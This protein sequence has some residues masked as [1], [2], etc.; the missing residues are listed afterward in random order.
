MRE[1]EQPKDLVNVEQGL[2]YLWHACMHVSV[3]CAST[4]TTTLI[5]RIHAIVGQERET[6]GALT[7]DLVGQT[8]SSVFGVF[9]PGATRL[10]SDGNHCVTAHNVGLLRLCQPLQVL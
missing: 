2:Y 1:R 6:N 5:I 9:G 10:G 4:T 3:H 7:G 8:G